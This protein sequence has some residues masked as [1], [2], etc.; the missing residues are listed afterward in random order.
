VGANRRKERHKLHSLT[1]YGLL[2]AALLLFTGCSKQ[3]ETQ[4]QAVVEKPS[5]AKHV[6]H[7]PPAKAQYEYA[8]LKLGMTTA[9]V[10]LIKGLPSSVAK[11]DIDMGFPENEIVFIDDKPPPGLWMHFVLKNEINSG[12]FKIEDYPQWRYELEERSESYTLVVSFN[13]A[14]RVTGISCFA[15]FETAACPPLLGLTVAMSEAAMIEKLG[16]PS[17]KELV[18]NGVEKYKYHNLNI[19]LLVKRNML[20]VIGLRKQA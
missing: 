2:I 14:R 7:A 6:R 11:Y 18:V 3:S 1:Q 13:Q 16:K 4:L 10:R 9:D 20:A 15:L 8:G 12:V 17:R 5:V 19:E